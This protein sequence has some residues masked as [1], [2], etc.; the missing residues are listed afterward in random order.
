MYYHPDEQP[1][2]EPEESAYGGRADTIV[3]WT[4]VALIL[5][6]TAWGLL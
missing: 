6:A 2:Y 3:F 1:E 5:A 4:V